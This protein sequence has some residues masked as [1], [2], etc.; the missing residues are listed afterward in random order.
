ESGTDVTVTAQLAD[1]HGNPVTEADRVVNWSAT[2]GGAFSTSSTL[3]DA[4]GAATVMF[5]TSTVAD[6]EHVVK[7]IDDDTP[8]ITGESPKITTQT[9]PAAQYV[10]TVSNETP[11]SGNDVTVTAQ[12]VDVHGN[13]VAE[14]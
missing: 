2:N 5:T 3:T 6:T 10:V 8:A 11:A 14:A 12:L 7:A 1:V 9:G 4:N 13:S